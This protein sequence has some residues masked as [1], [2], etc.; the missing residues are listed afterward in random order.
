MV[1]FDQLIDNIKVAKH[2]L[3]ERLATDPSFRAEQE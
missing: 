1:D 2:K 3:D